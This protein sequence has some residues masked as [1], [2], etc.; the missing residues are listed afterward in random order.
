[1][2]PVR[3]VDEQFLAEFSDVLAWA[4]QHGITSHTRFHIYKRNIEWLRTLDDEDERRR[5]QA[6]LESE[7][8]LTEMLSTMTESIELV[9]TIPVLRRLDV[10]IPK[11]LLKRAFSGPVDMSREDHTSNKARNAMFELKVAAMAAQ[12][13]IKPILSETNPDV[14]FE[15]EDRWVKIECKR[16]L[17]AERIIDRLKEGAKQLEK[18]VQHTASD[19]GIVAIS[20]SKLVNPG[21][22][23]LVSSSPQ[24]ELFQQLRDAMKAN[25]EQLAGM[26]R[27]WV[28][29]FIFY[30]SSVSHVPGRGNAPIN[31]GIVF[32]LDLSEQEFLRR[33][34]S[35][36]YV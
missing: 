31:S 1:M 15:F 32:P 13:G 34:A 36:L 22:L 9:E 23:F 28:S 33:L 24:N 2:D 7:N 27:P 6:Q 19:I 14:S 12:R 3:R 21:N 5:V 25:Q 10:V 8:R 35:A 18:S 16:V 20:L 17:T 11:E 29:G 30:L 26:Y 4:A